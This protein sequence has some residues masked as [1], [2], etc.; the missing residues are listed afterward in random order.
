M[1]THLHVK[2]YAI[3][4]SVELALAGG[5][6]ALTGETGAGKSILVDAVQLGLGGRASAGDV[7][8][9]S[10]R[11]DITLHFDLTR[12]PK[13]RDWLRERELE[14]GTECVLRRTVSAD[15]KSRGYINNAPVPLTSLRELGDCLLDIHGQQ[16]NQT[17]LLTSRQRAVLDASGGHD[18][19]LRSVALAHARWQAA[20]TAAGELAQAAAQREQRLDLLRFQV[21]ELAAAELRG[22]DVTALEAQRERLAHAGALIE[23]A[24]AALGALSDGDDALD[25]RLGAV[26]SLLARWR[27]ADARI[28]EAHELVRGAAVNL[29]EAS[30]A[31]SRGLDGLEADP[32]ALDALETRLALL[33]RL[34]RKHQTDIASLPALEARLCDELDALDHSGTRLA[35][36]EAEAAARLAEWR[37]AAAALSAARRTAATHLSEQITAWMQ[38][39]GMQGGRFQVSVEPDSE[40]PPAVLGMDQ[41]R[42]DVS[43]NPGMPLAPLARVAS[44]GELSRISLAIQVCLAHAESAASLIFDEVDAGIGGSVAEIV[45]RLL[46]RLGESRQVLCVTHLPQVAAQAHHHGH[47]SKLSSGQTTRSQLRLLEGEARVEEIARMLGGVH[48]TAASR[49]HAAEMLG[50]ASAPPA[51]ARQPRRA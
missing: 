23:T 8:P 48:I 15:G 18:E 7:R 50:Q 19:L 14:D 40:A 30:A 37:N 3:A 36:L 38:Q 35:E 27:H 4:D 9:G 46:R 10:E 28:A 21:Q 32:Q 16:E 20:H 6:T 31:L 1:L 45:G 51:P 39:L 44:G 34:A 41:V 26:A 47:V 12:L 11:A 22:L 5:M 29:R 13:A 33:Q 43:A 42:F 17:L 25:T 24:A 49:Q 2:G